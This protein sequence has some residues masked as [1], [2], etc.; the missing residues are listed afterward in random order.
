[1]Q[2]LY[3][4][5]N[6]LI[7]RE[8]LSR[9]KLKDIQRA[10]RPKQLYSVP[11]ATTSP[12][13]RCVTCSD[14]GMVK[15]VRPNG[16]Q[17]WDG[18]RFDV[19]PCA[20]ARAD[21]AARRAERSKS[22]SNLTPEM[23]GMT[24]ASYDQTRD[25]IAYAAAW[26]FLH[27][28]SAPPFLLLEGTYGSGKTHLMSAIAHEALTLGHQPLFTVVPKLMDW[29]KAAFG[30]KHEKAEADTF[31]Q[32]FADICEVDILL[33]DDLGAEKSSEWTQERLYMLI[34]DRYAANR[35]TVFSTNCTLD[36]FE[37]RIGSRLGDV[38]KCQHVITTDQD[39]RKS[40]ARKAQ[41]A[42]KKTA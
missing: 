35:R 37:R 32:R 38:L 20:C 34:N 16:K 21:F 22:A 42:K 2:Q 9:Q 11:I 4:E 23:A 12:Q 25:S 17:G 6:E 28:P 26:N 14:L 15:V 8:A 24:F 18:Y 1:M 19:E 3:D 39:Y 13:V 40:S 7:V 36:E 33:L 29:F 10:Q 41:R 30:Q 27:D 5:A 31:A